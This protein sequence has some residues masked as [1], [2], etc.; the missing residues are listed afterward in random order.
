[1]TENEPDY[2][3][4]RRVVALT[5]AGSDSGGNAGIQADLRAFHV[6]GVHGCTVLA[7]LTAQNPFG[8]RGILAADAGFVG[9]QLDAVLEAYAVSALKTGML[10]SPDVIEAVA[11]RLVL[12][13]RIS[14]VM[15]PVMVAT[16]GARLLQDDA[17]ATLT[18][19]LLPLATLITPNLPEAEVLTGRAIGGG[20]AIVDAARELGDTFGTAVLIKGGHGA[21]AEAEDILFDG[22][23]VY[24]IATPRIDQP[25]STHGTG[26]SLSAAIAAALACGKP[27]LDA[28]AEGKAYVYESIRTGTWVGEASAVLGT[29]A[30]LPIEQVRVDTL[31]KP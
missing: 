30:R 14:K 8:V 17:V 7:A 24:R 1:M 21:A 9:M 19:V 27:L 4:M 26:C 6:F 23:R 31:R 3:A 15:D 18:G 22:E 25:V 13:N 20:D 29:P 28:V 12:H 2:S 10:A 16:S 11:D 5:I